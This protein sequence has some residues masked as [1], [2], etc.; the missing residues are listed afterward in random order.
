[1]YIIKHLTISNIMY[2]VFDTS[3]SHSV[4]NC[5]IENNSTTGGKYGN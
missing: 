1:M 3:F 4:F 2:G 5:I